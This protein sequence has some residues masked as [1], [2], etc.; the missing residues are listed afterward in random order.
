MKTILAITHLESDVQI[1]HVA[2]E[3]K[4]SGVRIISVCTNA[5]SFDKIALVQ[6]KN[7]INLHFEGRPISP[8]GIWFATYPREDTL[9]S[10]KMSKYPYPGEYR[11]AVLQF[12]NDLRF[13]FDNLSFFPGKFEDILR[14]DSKLTLF[15][16]AYETGINVPKCTINSNLKT[17]KL[18]ERSGLYRKKLGFPSVVSYS[19]LSQSEE[20][21]TTV[22]QMSTRDSSCLMWQWQT[23]IESISHVRGVLVGDKAWFSKWDRKSSLESMVDFRALDSNEDSWESITIPGSLLVKLHGLQTR[24][25]LSI[26]CPEFLITPQGKW[27]LIDLNPCGDWYGFFGE[28]ERS[29]IAIAISKLF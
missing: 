20:I 4:S 24:L 3:S 16:I 9:F 8:T 19:S 17:K 26:C 22:N 18:I 14:G 2:A 1:D 28:K 25:K 29:E 7:K 27:I 5:I 10:S 15:R 6:N 23:P 12:M 13:A 11:S 21:V